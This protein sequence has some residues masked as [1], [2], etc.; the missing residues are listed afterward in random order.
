MATIKELKDRLNKYTLIMKAVTGFD[1]IEIH[2]H[3]FYGDEATLLIL[4]DGHLYD[5]E[6]YDWKDV[7]RAWE[8]LTV[9]L[10]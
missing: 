2:E 7:I 1:T 9:R 3:P 10:I 4:W 5:S 8:N 6:E